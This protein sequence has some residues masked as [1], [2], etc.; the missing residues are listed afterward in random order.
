VLSLPHDEDI[1]LSIVPV[2][3]TPV[4]PPDLEAGVITPGEGDYYTVTGQQGDLLGAVVLDGATT[5][6]ASF[7][8]DSLLELFND[9]AIEILAAND[10][11]PFDYCSQLVV[12]LPQTGSYY[13]RVS[14]SPYCPGCS[15]DYQL[16]VDFL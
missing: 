5:T 13:L 11:T 7:A 14:A 9:H 16:Y 3:V 8:L 12:A 6:C 2:S 10:D 4:T 15:F 1:G